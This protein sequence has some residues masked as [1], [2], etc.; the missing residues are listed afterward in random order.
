MIDSIS[1]GDC[2]ALLPSLGAGCVDLA[3]VD[4]PFNIGLAYP[5]YHDV[6]PE[7]EYLDWLASVFAALRRVLTPCAALW[8]QC[9]PTVQA[10]IAVLLKRMGFFFR[11]TVVWHYTFGPHQQRKFT[12]SFQALHWFTMDK[13]RFAFHADAVRV[14]SARQTVYRDKRANPLGRIPDD[15]WAI[16]RVCGTFRERIPGHRC[17]TP[18]AVVERIIKACSDVGGMV[19]DPMCGTGTTCHAAALHGRH[20]VGMELSAET[21]AKARRRLDPLATWEPS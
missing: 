13:E 10:E 21:A 3:Y 7:A 18:L 14:P 5:S 4:P 16:S 6:R 15:V 1:T 17:Q 19:L 9:G 8:V 12:P 20:F 11:Q 2:L